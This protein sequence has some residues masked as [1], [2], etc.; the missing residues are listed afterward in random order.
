MIH[1]RMKSVIHAFVL[2]LVMVCAVPSSQ[3]QTAWMTLRTP[4]M[5][6]GQHGVGCGWATLTTQLGLRGEQPGSNA[7]T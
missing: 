1:S 7:A 2:A 4:R 6:V 5:F 3:G